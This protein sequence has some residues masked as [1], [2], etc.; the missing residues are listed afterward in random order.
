MKQFIERF[1]GR[2]CELIKMISR[3]G[4]YTTPDGGYMIVEATDFILRSGDEVWVATMRA[5]NAFYDP[6]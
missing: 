1:S 6:V 3:N 4:H 2:T 5:F